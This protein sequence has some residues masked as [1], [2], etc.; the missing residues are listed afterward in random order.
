MQKG[1][2]KKINENARWGSKVIC[3]LWNYLEDLRFAD[4]E[5]NQLYSL[6][7]KTKGFHCDYKH[8]KIRIKYQF[9]KI[10]EN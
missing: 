5:V 6:R 4:A 10:D 9:L 3:L 8:A 2:F 7:D 1:L